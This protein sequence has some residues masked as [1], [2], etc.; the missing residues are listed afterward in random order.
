MPQKSQQVG[1]KAMRLA[2]QRSPLGSACLLAAKHCDFS[3]GLFTLSPSHMSCELAEVWEL[4]SQAG[5]KIYGLKR[6]V[7]VGQDV[8]F[9]QAI[10]TRGRVESASLWSSLC[11]AGCLWILPCQDHSLRS[12]GVVRH[13]GLLAADYLQVSNS[14]CKI[15]LPN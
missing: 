4:L 13:S 10:R 9:E 14:S 6:Q 7:Q 2:C 3:L 11:C 12:G 1:P 5:D 8:R 15:Y